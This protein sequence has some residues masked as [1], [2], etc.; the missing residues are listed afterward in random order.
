MSSETASFDDHDLP[1]RVREH[2]LITI[3]TDLSSMA[4]TQMQ[5]WQ[6]S[7]GAHLDTDIVDTKTSA[8]D[9]VTLADA[10]IEALVKGYL[11]KVCPHDE[12]VGEEGSEPLDPTKF[13]DSQFLATLHHFDAHLGDLVEVD[14]DEKLEWHVDPIDG[15]VNYVRGIEHSAFSVGVSRQAA[16]IGEGNWLIG[17]V[18]SPGL[19]ATW[20]AVAGEGAYRVEGRMA[21]QAA[22][23]AIPARRL[24]GTPSGLSGRLLATGF[25]YTG[26]NRAG[27][28]GKLTDLMEGYDD[29]R[30]CGSAA[31]DLCMVAEGRINCYA[32]RGLGIYDYAAGALIAE[33]AGIFVHRGGTGGPTAAADTRIELDRLVGII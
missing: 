30:R 25:A 31:I 18:S 1:A 14:H 10:Q 11:T 17:M 20:L 6:T 22:I 13:F 28:L 29:V 3:A 21:D 12:M 26:P 4:W 24:H 5:S 16:E 9:L 33:E 7:V 27:Q 8:N 32:E 23:N 15:T 19:N 2:F